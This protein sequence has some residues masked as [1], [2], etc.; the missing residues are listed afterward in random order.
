MQAFRWLP[1]FSVGST[2]FV[3]IGLW[4]GGVGYLSQKSQQ[5]ESRLESIEP[6]IARFEGALGEQEA[7]RSALGRQRDAL[8]KV[9]YVS[10][11]ETNRLG[12][13]VQQRI[14]DA[15]SGTGVSVAGS[16][17]RIAKPEDDRPWGLITVTLNLESGVS[18]L[19]A[20]MAALREL[21]PIVYPTDARM[22]VSGRR[23]GGEEQVL[24]TEFT[25]KA[26]Y[27]PQP[28]GD[29]REVKGL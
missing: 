7:I 6:R 4:L 16:Q 3:V 23:R 2:L 5:Y 27:L 24:A 12:A 13:E 11:Q 10:V 14:R 9:V 28:V 21:R 25:L 15:V 22:R 1:W 19:I 18:E 20:A 8:E 17:V 26:M 29:A